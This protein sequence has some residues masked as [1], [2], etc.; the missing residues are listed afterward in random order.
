MKA[1]AVKKTQF[2][3]NIPKIVCLIIKILLVLTSTYL[4]TRYIVLNYFTELF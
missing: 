2:N 3:S 1:T 4:H